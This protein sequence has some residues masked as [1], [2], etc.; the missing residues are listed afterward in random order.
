MVKTFEKILNQHL[1]HTN[2][3]KQRAARAAP[4][5]HLQQTTQSPCCV[6]QHKQI[7]TNKHLQ[8][9]PHVLPEQHQ[10]NQLISQRAQMYAH[11]YQLT[12]TVTAPCSRLRAPVANYSVNRASQQTSQSTKLVSHSSQCAAIIIG[13]LRRNR[14]RS[15]RPALPF[16]MPVDCAASA[17]HCFVAVSVASPRS[18]ARPSSLH[19]ATPTPPS[20]STQAHTHQRANRSRDTSTAYGFGVGMRSPYKHKQ[21]SSRYE[22]TNIFKIIPYVDHAGRADMRRQVHRQGCPQHA[23]AVWAAHKPKSRNY[24]TNKYREHTQIS[25]TIHTL[26]AARTPVSVTERTPP[27][28]RLPTPCD[29]QRRATP[30]SDGCRT[31]RK[32]ASLRQGGASFDGTVAAQHTH[33]RPNN[34]CRQEAGRKESTYRST[35]P[36]KDRQRTPALFTHLFFIFLPAANFYFLCRQIR[37][38]AMHVQNYLSLFGS[39]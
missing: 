22:Q 26:S 21:Q 31:A 34:T 17:P 37:T 5:K 16:M 11:K 6:K 27:L 7:N 32:Q 15:R 23:E 24:H 29:V 1:Q 39:D 28:K 4:N 33:I 35:L 18:V 36:L 2:H 3:T 12:E 9:K 19:A 30:P 20:S 38:K 25:R 13:A 14:H 10:S 8:H